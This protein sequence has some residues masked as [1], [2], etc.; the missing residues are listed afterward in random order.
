MQSITVLVYRIIMLQRT[1][2][3]GYYFAQTKYFKLWLSYALIWNIS[4]CSAWMIFTSAASPFAQLASE[5]ATFDCECS[6]MTL[7]NSNLC[8]KWYLTI[9]YYYC[10]YYKHH[11]L[12]Q[13]YAHVWLANQFQTFILDKNL[14]NIYKIRYIWSKILT[15]LITIVKSYNW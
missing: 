3:L 10:C 13:W 2:S 7:F 8:T 11:L 15:K 1:V 4:Q 12:S 5:K 9:Y 6:A 14:T